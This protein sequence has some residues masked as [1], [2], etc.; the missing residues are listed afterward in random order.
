MIS[1]RDLIGLDLRLH[2]GSFLLGLAVGAAAGAAVVATVHARERRR[3]EG[4]DGRT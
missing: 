4:E 3:G 1:L 2:R